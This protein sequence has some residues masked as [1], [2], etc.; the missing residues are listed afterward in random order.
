MKSK[1]NENKQ[2]DWNRFEEHRQV[3]NKEVV[4]AK[5]ADEL[6]ISVSSVLREHIEPGGQVIPHYHSVAELIHITIGKVELLRE[7]GWHKYEQGDTFLIPKGVVHSVRNVSA[8][9]SE[10]LSIFLPVDESN[11][12]NVFFDTVLVEEKESTVHE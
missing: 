2:L 7:D 9:I 1:V 10:Q 8:E 6:Q 11:V 12:G 3:W 5:E 4:N